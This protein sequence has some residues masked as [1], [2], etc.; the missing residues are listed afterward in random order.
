MPIPVLPI[1][2]LALPLAEIAGFVIVGE[3]IGALATIGLVLAT[4]VLGGILLRIQ[5]FGTL[6]RIR[7]SAESGGSPGRELVHAVMIMF[8]G[9]LL[10]LPGFI[11]DIVGIL[12]F[13][14][15][16]REVAWRLIRS[17]VTVVGSAG[18]GPSA[19]WRPRSR[20][21]TIDLDSD[22]FSREG[23]RTPPQRPA[24]DDDRG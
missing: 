9:F 8:A 12:L 11:T 3:E 2:L 5:G 24:I 13:I 1:L 18:F 20:G 21:D 22:D 10:L 17:R 4:S 16:V 23:G 6:A 14:P 7:M 15:P 19:A